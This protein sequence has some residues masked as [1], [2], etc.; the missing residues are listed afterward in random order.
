MSKAPLTDT[1]LP[2]IGHDGGAAPWGW[3]A[4]I[5]VSGCDPELLHSSGL[6]G[7]FRDQRRYR[8]FMRELV[9]TIDMKRYGRMRLRRFGNGSLHGW[10][11]TQLIYTSSI[12]GHNN[13]PGSELLF[14]VWSCK[15]FD[16]DKA[17]AVAVKYFG[18][19]ARVRFVERGHAA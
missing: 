15:P 11:F 4:L 12:V 8:A 14:D 9:T 7:W 3:H 13:E 6:V 5:D 18:G 10:T 16:P 1:A 17:A 2:V 19:R